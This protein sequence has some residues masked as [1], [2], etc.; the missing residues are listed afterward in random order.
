M[1][2]LDIIEKYGDEFNPHAYTSYISDTQFDDRSALIN[3]CVIREIKPTVI[4]EFGT[5]WGRC[6][7]DILLAL[8]KNSNDFVFKPYELENDMRKQSQENLDKAFG[9]QAPIIGGDI[10][11]ATDIPKNIDYLFID[12]YHDR[13]TTKWVFQHLIPQH[14]HSG[15][16]VQIHDL[17]FSGDNWHSNKAFLEEGNYM[18]ELYKNGK[19]PLKK[20][21]FT[22]E[23]GN[24]MESTWWEVK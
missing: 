12:N 24:K 1:K 13:E 8:L 17:P 18:F 5:K 19:F 3:Y 10:T 7:H 23:E 6:T 11:L 22:Y 21:Y 14:C 2:I 9:D 15:T 4:V 16:V 20:I